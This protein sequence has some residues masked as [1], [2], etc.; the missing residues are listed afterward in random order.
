M[1][2]RRELAALERM[3]RLRAELEL[4][5][6]AAF[7]IHVLAAHE[8]AEASRAAMEQSYAAAAPLGIAEARMANV[9]AGRAA[10]ELARAQHDLSQMQP[11]FDMLRQ[12]AGREF[13]RAE[14]L[15][16]L[17]RAERRAARKRSDQI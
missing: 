17:S 16:E 1:V 5:K 8:R 7:R 3:A 10:R 12:H 11:R 9:Q 15:A 6:L 14:A 2:N 4:K 13:G